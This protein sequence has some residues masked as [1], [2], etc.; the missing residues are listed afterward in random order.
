M[1]TTTTC[2]AWCIS[3]HADNPHLHYQTDRL[4]PAINARPFAVST[5]IDHARSQAGVYLD[6]TEL[7]P[8]HA[9]EL[10]AL[11]LD[12]AD[13]AEAAVSQLDTAEATR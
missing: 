2:P 9:R 8:V 1:Q 4:T 5:F 7:R 3:D 12:C 10:A 11:L 6:S 13:T